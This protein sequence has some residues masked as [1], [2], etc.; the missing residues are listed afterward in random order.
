MIDSVGIKMA[1]FT[2]IKGKS[3]FANEPGNKSPLELD[4][5]AF[6]CKVRVAI[7]IPGSMA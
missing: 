4:A 2:F 1:S 7:S 5:V 3:I 6:S